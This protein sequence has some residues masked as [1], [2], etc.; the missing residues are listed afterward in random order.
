MI[1]DENNYKILF[2]LK[3]P[4][5]L[6]FTPSIKRDKRVVTLKKIARKY[7]DYFLLTIVETRKKTFY[8]KFFKKF[9]N[10]KNTPSLRILNMTDK[11]QRYKFHGQ[12]KTTLVDNFF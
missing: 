2:D 8:T 10:V 1:A 11:V 7:K 4:S 5:A 12:Y 6:Y 9:L 3:I